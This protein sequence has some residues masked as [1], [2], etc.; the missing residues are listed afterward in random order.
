MTR[1]EGMAK[2]TELARRQ[3]LRR[4]AEALEMLDRKPTPDEAERLSRA[5]II[6]VICE[7]CPE[8]EAAFSAWADSD[9]CDPGKPVAAIVTAVK[10]SRMYRIAAVNVPRARYGEVEADSEADALDK[11]RTM[12]A[13]AAGVAFGIYEVNPGQGAFLVASFLNGERRFTAAP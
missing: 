3:P 7:R 12:S 2:M 10:E 11:A 9:D 1:T 8:A 4:L 13:K 6:D 5:V